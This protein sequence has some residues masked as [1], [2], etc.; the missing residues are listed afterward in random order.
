MGLLTSIGL[1]LLFG[2]PTAL[3]PTPWF[4][5]M[6]P[7][8]FSDYA[9]LVLTAVLLGA[10]LGVH[11]Y[12]KNS[13][14]LCDTVSFSGGLAGFLAFGCP[15]CNQLL[16]LLFGTTALLAYLEPYR[17]IL[18]SVSTAILAGALWWRIRN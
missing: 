8:T 7:S 6:I 12:K 2:I 1:I 10:Y 4:V 15:I 14:P 17:P 13:S 11:L 16:V 18:G 5:R 9:F 3:I